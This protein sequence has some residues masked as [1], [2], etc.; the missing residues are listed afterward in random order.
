MIAWIA[1]RAGVS[2]ATI[3]IIASLAA[4]LIIVLAFIWY[5]AEREREGI[6]KADARWVEANARMQAATTRAMNAADAIAQQREAEQR[7]QIKELE[8][9]AAKGDNSTVG[10]GT[11]AVL[12]QLRR[13]Q[14]TR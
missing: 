9:E 6:A 2:S 5:G 11:L 4:A 7:A 12:E 3:K 8:H 14:G 10:P 13:Q 1:R